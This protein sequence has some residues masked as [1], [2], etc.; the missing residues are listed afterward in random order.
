M[1]LFYGRSCKI[2]FYLNLCFVILFVCAL[3]LGC[4]VLRH[5]LNFTF[6]STVLN[7][8]RCSA[9]LMHLQGWWEYGD[10]N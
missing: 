2:A 5:K 3:F 7:I 6:L 9:R 8:K 10:E 4:P 1:D